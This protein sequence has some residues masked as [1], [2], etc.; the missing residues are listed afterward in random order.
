[1]TK[2]ERILCPVDFSEFSARACKYAHSLA[3]QYQADLFL[4]YVIQPMH[5]IYPYCDFPL[6]DTCLSPGANEEAEKRLREFARNHGRSGV[7]PKLVTQE[8]VLLPDAILAFADRNQVDLIVMGTHGRHGFDRLTLGSV[9]EKV[10]RRT[11][12]PVLAVRKPEHDFIVSAEGAESVQLRRILYCTD[13]SDNA[14]HALS[15]AF[16]LA[17]EYNAELTLLHV[18]DNAGRVRSL[19]QRT[20]ETLRKLKKLVPADVPNWCSVTTAVRAGRPYQEIVRLASEAQSDLVIVGVRGHG[21][22]ELGLFGSTTHRILQMGPCPVLAV[23]EPAESMERTEV[24]VRHEQS[25]VGF[26]RPSPTSA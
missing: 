1:M 25:P 23:H 3:K 6:P 19:E 21:L 11:H 2:F 9:T 24:L 26:S 14:D 18:L 17:M 22:L 20:T 5:V 7:A 15:Y 16:S 8:N 4:Q 10:L 13:F 12:C